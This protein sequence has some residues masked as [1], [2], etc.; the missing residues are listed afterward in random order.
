MYCCGGGVVAEGSL[1]LR[2]LAS[3]WKAG[4]H[5]LPLLWT[6]SGAAA[7]ARLGSASMSASSSASRPN[8]TSSLG[9][10]A[11]CLRWRLFALVASP[12][13]W[14]SSGG[15]ALVRLSSLSLWILTSATDAAAAAAAAAVAAAVAWSRLLFVVWM[16]E[17]SIGGVQALFRRRGTTTLWRRLLAAADPLGVQPAASA[18]VGAVALA[19]FGSSCQWCSGIA[20]FLKQARVLGCS[21][22]HSLVHTVVVPLARGW[23]GLVRPTAASVV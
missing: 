13:G 17:L 20:A 14:R 21:P 6:V 22:L 9:L 15:E 18:V 8:H 3:W 5:T 23:H 12:L 10:C 1:R 16:V 4:F 7:V 19:G 11:V 2:A